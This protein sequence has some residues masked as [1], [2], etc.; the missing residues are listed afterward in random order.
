MTLSPVSCTK[1]RTGNGSATTVTTY[2]THQLQLENM[3]SPNT[4]NLKTTLVIFVVT[5]V[6]QEKL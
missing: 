4:L 6:Q 3:L 2:L 5:C 1:M